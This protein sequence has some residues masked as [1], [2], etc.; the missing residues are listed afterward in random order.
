MK[1]AKGGRG[2]VPA[3]PD[4]KAGAKDARPVHSQQSDGSKSLQ[5]Q[6]SQPKLAEKDEPVPASVDDR[7]V[8]WH[9]DSFKKIV[10]EMDSSKTTVGGIMAAMI[11]QIERQSKR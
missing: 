11:Y 5:K 1:A 6:P 7:K 4:P 9:F 3:K 2:K 10:S 8:E